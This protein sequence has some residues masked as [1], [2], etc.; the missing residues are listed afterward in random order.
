MGLGTTMRRCAI[1]AAVYLNLLSSAAQA[2]TGNDLQVFCANGGIE[3]DL[4]VV[5]IIDTTNLWRQANAPFKFCYP[6][7]STI[8]QSVLVVRKYLNDNPQQLHR[9]GAELVIAALI[10]AFPCPKKP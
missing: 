4:Y 9:T 6:S 3:C 7:T 1:A 8:Q 5:G 2:A 10:H